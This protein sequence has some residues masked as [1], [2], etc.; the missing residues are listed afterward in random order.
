MNEPRVRRFT[1]ADSQ[2][3]SRP[4]SHPSF[5]LKEIEMELLTGFAM[6]LCISLLIFR[7]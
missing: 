6:V 7:K 4:A 5:P 3:V 2:P 1:H